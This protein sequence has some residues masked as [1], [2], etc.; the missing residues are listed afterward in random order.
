MLGKDPVGEKK[1]KM[2]D[3]LLAGSATSFSLFKPRQG[4]Q[5]ETA[6]SLLPQGY[7]PHFFANRDKKK[8]QRKPK[9]AAQESTQQGADTEWIDPAQQQVQLGA[10]SCLSLTDLERQ[11]ELERARQAESQTAAERDDKVWSVSQ[12]GPSAPTTG[13]HHYPSLAP[14][15]EAARVAESEREKKVAEEREVE[16]QR[17]READKARADRERREKEK[18][19]QKAQERR[20]LA[21]AHQREEENPAATVPAPAPQSEADK[22]AAELAEALGAAST[23]AKADK[24]KKKK[25]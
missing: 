24:K 25:K 6:V 16:R 7:I 17:Q 12:A 13:S 3:R 8:Q 5:A 1:K 14:T 21:E 11:A 4:Q 10:R 20:K 9:V 2:D 15:K 19:D 18:R 23:E 22:L